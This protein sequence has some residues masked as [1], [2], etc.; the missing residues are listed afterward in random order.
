MTIL[1]IP[2]RILVDYT[3][4]SGFDRSEMQKEL[5]S[6]FKEKLVNAKSKC[7]DYIIVR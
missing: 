6:S 5:L 7:N 3:N 4:H 1:K 2:E